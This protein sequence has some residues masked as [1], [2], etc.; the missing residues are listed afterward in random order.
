MKTDGIECKNVNCYCHYEQCE[1]SC[2]EVDELPPEITIS[3]KEAV[4]R[5]NDFRRRTPEHEAV[6]KTLRSIVSNIK[7]FDRIAKNAESA[8]SVGSY[9]NYRGTYNGLY[10]AL[11]DL[12]HNWIKRNK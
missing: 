5:C 3:A 10:M 9:F 1:Y 12:A 6:V 8:A 4:L 7:L 11:A 2:A